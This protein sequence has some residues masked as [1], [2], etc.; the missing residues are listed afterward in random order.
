MS[1]FGISFSLL[2]SGPVRISFDSPSGEHFTLHVPH[3]FSDLSGSLMELF[4][5]VKL[6]S[7]NLQSAGRKGFWI[8]IVTLI[9]F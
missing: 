7:W 8:D 6:L 5:I 2:L 1:V 9:L 3:V 4:F